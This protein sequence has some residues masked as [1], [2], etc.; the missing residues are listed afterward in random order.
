MAEARFAVQ[1]TVVLQHVGFEVDTSRKQTQLYVSKSGIVLYIPHPYFIFKN[2]RRSFWHGVDK[3][4]F[5][6]Y[7]IPLSV[8]TSL[9]LG[10]FVWVLK[11]KPDAWI[12]TNT[13]SDVL[14]RL[15][16]KNPI[17]KRIPMQYRMPVLCA[18]LVI[19]CVSA[20]TAVQRFLL[21][22]VLKYNGYIYEGSRN[23]SRKTRIWSF[24]L[25]TFFFHPLN[26]TEAY[27]SCL[28][29]QPLPDLESTVKRFMI[30][31]EPLYEG[32]PDEWNRLV[33]LSEKFLKD[34]GPRFQRM[35][36][37]KY[38]FAEN[39]MSD[40]WL[41]Y[42]YLAQ[43]ESLCINSNWFGI[44]FAKYTPTHLQASRAA[45]LIYNLIK[46][47]KSLDRSTF[48][49]L[50]GGLVPLDMSQYRYVFNTTRLPGREMDV[51]TQYEGIK[52]IVVIYK[53]RFYQLEVLHPRTNHQLSPYQ[54]EMALETILNSD[55][56]TDPVEALIPAFTTA[57]RTEWADIRDKHFVNNAYNVKP[58][59]VIEESIFVLS[60]DDV[61]PNSIDE[62]SLLL[63]CGNGH[64]RWSDKSFNLVVTPDGYSGVHVE[65]SW[66]DALTLAHVLE[67]CYLTDETGE[68]FEKD[69]HV[70]KLDEDE[71]A[72]KQGKFEV[73]APS[74]IRFTLD[75]E[76]KVSVNAVHER[77]S[78][79]VRDL[80]LYVCRFDE[81]GKN[82][83]KKFGCSPDAW[84]QMAM[85]LA[86]F[87]DQGH[88]DQTYEA[89]SLRMYRKGRT[90]TI[91]TVSKDSCAFVR[92]MENPSLSKVEKAKLLRKACEKHQLYSRDA[93]AGHGV[94]RHL[95]ALACVSA[96]TGHASEFL[97]LALRPK[98]KLSTS[99]V[100]TRQLPPEYHTNNNTSLFETPNG[101]FGPVADDGYGV[102]YC[103]YG[104]NLLYFTITSKHSCPKTS[105][106][107]FADQLVTAL[108][109]MA[110]LGG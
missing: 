71:R 60:L 82:F 50:F 24:I 97:Q 110:A 7:P 75:R 62:R 66:G 39:Y 41:K 95:F 20:F 1:P 85:Q 72:L 21:R 47:K 56:E 92:G 105:S 18:N 67:Y 26:K 33:K 70:K 53:G 55:E 104:E 29:A 30:S 42:V 34:E 61:T 86:Y 31:V 17:S 80:D 88:F 103:I 108:Q 84:V 11:S 19:G 96:G 35:L 77:Y 76:L 68:L 15:D 27:E 28:P 3:V 87:R 25:K 69:G 4:Q 45:S 5:A 38:M 63:L 36:K 23:H 98:W 2:M 107:G 43:R 14:W 46:I 9:A 22:Q 49:P 12:R 102:C 54:L 32:K 10:V 94:D 13:I 89:A 90:E 74:R 79:E 78:K 58:L 81:Y 59:R 91:R 73:F 16:E 101:G 99:Q 106:K 51:L 65:H 83:P 6:L 52:H 100:L 57:P 93:V 40:W 37:V 44:P 8:V 109:E 64:N 48:P